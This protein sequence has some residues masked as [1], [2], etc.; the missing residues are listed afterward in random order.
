MPRS[1]KEKRARKCSANTSSAGPP[2]LIAAPRPVLS[3]N[4]IGLNC[5]HHRLHQGHVAAQ[6]AGL[7]GAPQPDLRGHC[8]VM[9]TRCRGDCRQNARRRC[10]APA[11]GRLQHRRASSTRSSERPTWVPS[12]FGART[13]A[14]VPYA[15]GRYTTAGV[16]VHGPSLPI[17]AVTAL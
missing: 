6:G 12:R 15:V 16:L 1:A 13:S 7:A 9:P 10:N 2:L 3:E 4:F 8:R 11:P 14:S 5:R 17:P